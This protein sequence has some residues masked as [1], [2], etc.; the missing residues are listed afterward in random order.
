MPP[1]NVD[2]SQAEAAWSDVVETTLQ[3]VDALMV[4]IRFSGI[5]L[6]ARAALAVDVMEMRRALRLEKFQLTR[7]DN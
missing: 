2:N 4:A 6:E 1:M 5:S 7:K 3:E